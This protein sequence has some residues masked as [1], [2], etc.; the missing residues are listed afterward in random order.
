[1]RVTPCVRF[2]LILAVLFTRTVSLHP[3]GMPEE[4]KQGETTAAA[5]AAAP[6]A[7]PLMSIVKDTKNVRTQDFLLL[8]DLDDITGCRDDYLRLMQIDPP[9]L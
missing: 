9:V 1:M 5:P 6:A 4:E 8:L 3:S 2:A 7:P